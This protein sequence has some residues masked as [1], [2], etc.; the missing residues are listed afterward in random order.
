M[1]VLQGKDPSHATALQDITR[2]LAELV[3]GGRRGVKQ[4][5][6]APA[7][8]ETIRCR[9][10]AGG[11]CSGYACTARGSGAPADRPPAAAQPRT[12]AA[13]VDVLVLMTLHPCCQRPDQGSPAP[14]CSQRVDIGL[15]TDAVTDMARCLRQ[16]DV[17]DPWSAAHLRCV[18]LVALVERVF[19][20]KVTR[21]LSERQ[22]AQRRHALAA[23]W[24][25][26][27]M[28]RRCRLVSERGS[29]CWQWQAPAGGAAW[30]VQTSACPARRCG[31]TRY[32]S[33]SCATQSPRRQPRRL[34]ESTAMRT[35]STSTR[36]SRR[37]RLHHT[38]GT[39]SWVR[40]I[41]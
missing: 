17:D 13:G 15:W 12:R 23:S 2:H 24:A 33:S 38:R 37:L 16:P 1:A 8:A 31:T 19:I 35:K 3:Y 41:C 36:C 25:A 22:R 21:L 4:K 28:P 26:I 20:L 10:S 29:W 30:C 27:S 5:G 7:D 14:P 39:R 34:A 9:A 11:D 40:R 6:W 18:Q 32:G